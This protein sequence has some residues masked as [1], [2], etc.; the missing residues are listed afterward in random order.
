M[1]DVQQQL[2]MM[3]MMMM[4]MVCVLLEIFYSSDQ[5]TL[6]SHRFLF[7]LL[8]VGGTLHTLEACIG[9]ALNLVKL[10][11]DPGEYA[12]IICDV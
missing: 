3:M 5:K 1:D 4:V 9:V 8:S 11:V 10:S 7:P 2:V 6:P 12:H